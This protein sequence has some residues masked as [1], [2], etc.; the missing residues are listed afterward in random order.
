MTATTQKFSTSAPA[1]RKTARSRNQLRKD[2]FV[3]TIALVIVLAMMA[4]IFWLASL[5]GGGADY[6]NDYWPM[7]P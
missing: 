2:R 6:I 1:V 4:L 7:M 3:A 5:G